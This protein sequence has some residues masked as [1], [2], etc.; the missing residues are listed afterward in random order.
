MVKTALCEIIANKTRKN[1]CRLIGLR[2]KHA[3][4]E[5]KVKGVDEEDCEP[6]A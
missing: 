4:I 2:T 1:R 5:K 6:N 3:K